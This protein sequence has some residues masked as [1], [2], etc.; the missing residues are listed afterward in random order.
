V[1]YPG[2]A[3]QGEPHAI[4]PPSTEY[5]LVHLTSADGNSIAAI[6]GLAAGSNSKTATGPRPT[7]PFFYGN[8]M[9]MADCLSE[10]RRFRKLGANV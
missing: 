2:H 3:T 6:F 10:F 8:G 7:M 4:L 5:E 9:C 1:I